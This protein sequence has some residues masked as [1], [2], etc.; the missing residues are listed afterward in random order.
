MRRTPFPYLRRPYQEV[1]AGEAAA[2]RPISNHLHFGGNDEGSLGKRRRRKRRRRRRRRKQLKGGLGLGVRTMEGQGGDMVAKSPPTNFAQD[3]DDDN[4][5]PTEI[6]T[7][8]DDFYDVDDVDDDD[9]VDAF[10]EERNLLLR[11]RNRKPFIFGGGGVGRK[12]TK[13]EKPPPPP[14]R[15]RPPKEIPIYDEVYDDEF[16]LISD[17]FDLDRM[18]DD[19]IDV[20][21]KSKDS[22]NK[23]KLP[24]VPSFASDP[25]GRIPPVGFA[26]Q[27][28]G[29][30]P[31]SPKRPSSFF[32]DE[33]GFFKD[34]AGKNE[35]FHKFRDAFEN[36]EGVDVGNE[37]EDFEDAFEKAK[38]RRRR[39][40]RPGM[41]SGEGFD[42]HFRLPR[43][44]PLRPVR[45]EGG[46]HLPRQQNPFS[47]NDLGEQ[48]E[49]FYGDFKSP[50]PPLSHLRGRRPFRSGATDSDRG[51]KDEEDKDPFEGGGGGFQS[52]FEDFKRKPFKSDVSDV[53]EFRQDFFD[54]A[55][56][57]FRLS[58]FDDP[59]KASNAVDDDG[60]GGDDKDL[61]ADLEQ[62]DSLPDSAPPTLYRDQLNSL[63]EEGEQRQ[64]H[65]VVGSG[66]GGGGGGGDGRRGKKPVAVGGGG[67]VGAGRRPYIDIPQAPLR[68]TYSE[69]EEDQDRRVS[70]NAVAP[71]HQAKEGRRRPPP[72]RPAAAE[73][74]ERPHPGDGGKDK[75]GSRRPQQQ[76]RLV[77]LSSS[78]NFL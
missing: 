68:H 65:V 50:P 67:S 25:F 42:T 43:L 35:D 78:N 34:P 53:G 1:A 17:D 9:F 20:T 69:E 29:E 63:K 31:P 49:D 61:A 58:Q 24:R 64:H 36:E 59:F 75:K 6:S 13:K 38:G 18:R 16:Y 22:V 44:R 51:T 28:I 5:D 55:F 54:D 71:P 7:H 45:P 76:V 21:G 56:K 3:D 15:R 77:P 32:G 73:E 10:A 2:A 19:E 40:L 39:P 52:Q 37:K 57:T 66:G 12:R 72:R 48:D 30:A 62:E 4:D 70:S 26:R 41:I 23:F 74:T 14:R 46:F 60:D 33:E 47:N 8:G 27:V 11:P